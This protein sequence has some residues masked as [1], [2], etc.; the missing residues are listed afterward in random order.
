MNKRVIEMHSEFGGPN[1]V[2][3]TIAVESESGKYEAFQRNCSS[4]SNYDLTLVLSGG[5]KLTE[6]AANFIFPALVKDHGYKYDNTE[7]VGS[8]AVDELE[9]L[10]GYYEGI[11][12]DLNSMI[13]APQ[14][15][16]ARANALHKL[17]KMRDLAAPHMVKQFNP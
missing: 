9:S 12:D 8:T 6:A 5:K 7:V 1:K 16:Q 2:L 14:D 4:V 11:K 13:L 10:S 15:A 17:V 3:I